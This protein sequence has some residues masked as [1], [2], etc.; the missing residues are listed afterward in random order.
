GLWRLPWAHP[1]GR[2][3]EQA[4]LVEVHFRKCRV[5]QSAPRVLGT[6]KSR[7]DMSHRRAAFK[8][9]GGETPARR[10]VVMRPRQG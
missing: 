1:G 4:C 2:R 3:K 7:E 5:A 9:S 10:P 6:S 8:E